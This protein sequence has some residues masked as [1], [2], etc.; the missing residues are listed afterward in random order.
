MVN[1]LVF[2]RETNGEQEY[3]Q[4]HLVKADIKNT[5]EAITEFCTQVSKEWYGDEDV[6]TDGDIHYHLS[7]T[8]ATRYMYHKVLTNEEFETL[9][10]LIY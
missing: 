2:I 8:L 9:N 6:Y 7:D 4:K 10:R 3:T 1:L 5:D